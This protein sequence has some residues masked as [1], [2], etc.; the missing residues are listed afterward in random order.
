MRATASFMAVVA[1]SLVA[2]RAPSARADDMACI[3]AAEHELAVRK[4]QK[5]RDALKELAVCAA[6]ACPAA[7]RNECNRR[8]VELNAALPTVVLSAT[9]GTGNDMSA[10]TVTIDGAPLAA[11]LDGRAVAVDPGNHVFRFEAAGKT[12][13]EKTVIVGEGVKDRHIEVAFAPASGAAVVAPVPSPS[14]SAHPLP[15]SSD[16]G[17]G[18]GVRTAGWV[19]GSVGL[20]G[21]IAAGVFGGLAIAGASNAKSECLLNCSANTNPAARADMQTASTY[22]TVSTAGFIAGGALL[23]GGV[24]MILVG[25]P[26]PSGS[27]LLVHPAIA[28][29]GGGVAVTGGF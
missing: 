1:A 11:A 5:L 2:A 9:D 20:A 26:K 17:R 4:E 21:G 29:N 14:A 10:V 15:P 13:V 19:V 25:G 28:A 22:A 23:A 8:L 18:G 12:A 6:P 24:V 16:T 27:A 7:V 3:A